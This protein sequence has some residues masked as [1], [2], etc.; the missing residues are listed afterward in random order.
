MQKV[1]IYST[2]KSPRLLYILTELFTRQL[3]VDFELVSDLGM[4]QNADTL[5]INYSH[6]NI[7]NSLQIKP[8]T[9]LFEKTIKKQ[10]IQV[11][12]WSNFPV[13]F[14]S[15]NEEIPFDIFAASFYLLSRYEE[16]LPAKRDKFGRYLAENSILY[17]L[18][19]IQKPIVDN[20]LIRF[21]EFIQTKYPNFQF[22]KRK[23]KYTPTIDI[24]NAYAFLHKGFVRTS[25]SLLRKVLCLQF[26]YL[27]QQILVLIGREPD[28]YDTFSFMAEIHEK[29]KI[30]PLY[31]FLVGHYNKY[32]TNI[33]TRNKYFQ[34]IIK[35]QLNNAQIGWHP[36]TKS[37]IDSKK[38][39]SEKQFLENLLQTEINCSRNHFLL[40]KIPETYESLIEAGI[41]NDYSMGYSEI[42][43]FRAGISSPFKF[44]N[45]KREKEENLTIYPFAFMDAT[46]HYYLKISPEKSFE[47]IKKI[48]DEV[49]AV[50]GNLIS[51]WHNESLS[52][53]RNWKGWKAVYEGMLAYIQK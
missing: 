18:N 53:F 36:S 22:P 17:E 48:I 9:L 8:H 50:E 15:E 16:Y 30:R 1:L 41:L 39:K 44:Y 25:V 13:I 28:P 20:W 3:K 40:L 34:Q 4:F 38:L 11:S 49:K 32:D 33:S 26:D 24:D 21:S 14:A 42:N 43:G 51:L 12:S 7:A 35:D 37:H 6:Q 47:E 5:K 19:I 10:Q 2:E 31:F 29:F 52:N 45:L 46:F 27:K 23:F